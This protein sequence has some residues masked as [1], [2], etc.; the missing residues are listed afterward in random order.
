M[1]NQNE[2]INALKLIQSICK[3]NED[4]SACP[5]REDNSPNPPCVIQG[6][7]PAEWKIKGRET[8]WRA[9]D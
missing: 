8:S 3:N 1:T 9:F 4:C 7:V 5:F 6:G 2:I